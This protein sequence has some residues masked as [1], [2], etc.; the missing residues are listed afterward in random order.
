[1]GHP[2]WSGRYIYD[3]LAIRQLK[4]ELLQQMQHSADSA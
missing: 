3:P 1:M 4:E 2:A